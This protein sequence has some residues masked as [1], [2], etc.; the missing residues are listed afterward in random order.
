MSHPWGSMLVL[1]LASGELDRWQNTPS[2]LNWKGALVGISFLDF[3][4]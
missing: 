4:A 1:A 3:K 2:V